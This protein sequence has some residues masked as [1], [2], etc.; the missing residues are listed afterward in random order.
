[1]SVDSDWDSWN[2]KF[3]E[4]ILRIVNSERVKCQRARCVFPKG[5]KSQYVFSG[6]FSDVEEGSQSFIRS[7]NEIQAGK[8]R[9]LV[10]DR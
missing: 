1:M 9:A 7:S 5:T 4:K 3:V 10:S 6:T 2:D 8:V